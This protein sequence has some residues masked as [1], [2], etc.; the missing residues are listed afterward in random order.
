MNHFYCTGAVEVRAQIAA[1][2][3][4]NGVSTGGPYTS[5]I[6]VRP[7]FGAKLGI[8]KSSTWWALVYDQ[9]TALGY[10][11]QRSLPEFRYIHG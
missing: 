6:R 1:S 5:T 2:G 7:I 3:Q 4:A 11:V 8:R 10:V 9:S